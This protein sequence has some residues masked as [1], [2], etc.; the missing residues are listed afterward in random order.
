MTEL[1]FLIDLLLNHKLPKVTRDAVAM[2]LKDVETALSANARMPVLAAPKPQIQVPAHLQG[3]APSTIAAMMKHEA[4]GAVI[5]PPTSP[6]TEPVAI[7]AQTPAA[8]AAIAQRN[9]VIAQAVSGT[10]EKGQKSP[11][12]W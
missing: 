10:H 9:Q 1:G 8:Q 7:V 6:S 11:R 12:K 3:Q 2:R 4:Q 5:D